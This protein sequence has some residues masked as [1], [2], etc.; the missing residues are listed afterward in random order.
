M[1]YIFVDTSNAGLRSIQS[2]F[3]P[4]AKIAGTPATNTNNFH[5]QKRTP[6]VSQNGI[7]WTGNLWYMPTEAGQNHKGLN[8]PSSSLRRPNVDQTVSHFFNNRFSIIWYSM[9][10]TGVI[11]VILQVLF[12][13][14]Q[15]A[16]DQIILTGVHIILRF[17]WAAEDSLTPATLLSRLHCPSL[18]RTW[19]QLGL[20]SSR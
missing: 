5:C 18:P 14:D 19:L 15:I 13:L 1:S 8:R 10:Q 11:G 9:F 7:Y 2:G 16:F 20:F 17:H 6:T 12:R 3:I 4:A